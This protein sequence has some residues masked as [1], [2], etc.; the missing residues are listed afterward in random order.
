M[1]GVSEI[2]SIILIVLIVVSLAGM[3]WTWYTG[4][5]G[6]VTMVNTNSTSTATTALGMQMRIEAAK[7]I[8]GNNVSATIRNTGT[9]DIDLSKLGTYV[10]GSLSY[11]YTP[12]TS[13][14]SPG[15]TVNINITNKTR[16][17]FNKILKITLDSGYEDYRTIS[18]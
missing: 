10:D 16:A 1:K 3:T 8:S 2:I 11:P 4:I 18:C 7:Y 15:Y 5:I 17:C 14:L 9:V 12:N 6:T 13:R